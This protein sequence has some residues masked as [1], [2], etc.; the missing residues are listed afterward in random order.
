MEVLGGTI[1][2]SGLCGIIGLMLVIPTR[3][4]TKATY[5]IGAILIVI[6]FLTAG[7]SV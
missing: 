7:M 5:I 2:V 6:G 3:R 1:T 4:S